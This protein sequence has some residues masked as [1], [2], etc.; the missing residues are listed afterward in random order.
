VVQGASRLEV[1]LPDVAGTF[2]AEIVGTDPLTDLAVI[3]VEG[4]GFPRALFGNASELR[5]GNLVVALGN[6][7]GLEGGP[8][9]TLGIVSNTERS[10]TLGTSTFYDI[11]QTDAAINP[12]N[13]GGPLINLKGEVI[14]INAVLRGEAQNIG[15]AISAST[16]QSVYKALVAPPH[17]VIRPWLGVVF[18]TVI[19]D[20]AAEADLP[21]KA[22]VLVVFIQPDSPAGEAGLAQGDV[23]TFFAG[24][25]VTEAT[26]L[27][28]T[29]WRHQIGDEVRITYWR[30]QEEKEVTIRLSAERPE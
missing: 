30:G 27:I 22:G 29:L 24:E 13:S 7:L 21:R 9:V 11:I 18:Q 14:G 3:K 8:T 6:A 20:I 19:P 12:G 15:F 2:E 16:V 26:Q 17:R 4:Q 1:A 23:V 5:P 10:F 28:K 25:R